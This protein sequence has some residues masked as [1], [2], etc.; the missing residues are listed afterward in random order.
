MKNSLIILSLLILILAACT[1][2]E[3]IKDRFITLSYQQTQCADP[4]NN[5]VDDSITLKNVNEHLKSNGIYVA[6]L[7]IKQES[8]AEICTAC[9][10]KTGKI[11]YL[12]TF[13]DRDMKKKAESVG[14]K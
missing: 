3:V 4:W 1:K 5:S 2:S 8:M 13:D 10:C 14:F 12:S 11:I 7:L 9:T 6:S